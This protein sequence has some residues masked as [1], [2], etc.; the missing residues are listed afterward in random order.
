[1]NMLPFYDNPLTV[2]E[3]NRDRLHCEQVTINND[4]FLDALMYRLDNGCT[5][6]SFPASF[7]HWH[8]MS[9]KVNRWAKQGVLQCTVHTLYEPHRSNGHSTKSPRPV[10]TVVNGTLSKTRGAVASGK[11]SAVYVKSGVKKRDADAAV[12]LNCSASANGE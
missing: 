8:P 12:T 9:V 4:L 7:G 2:I 10:K 6:R 11:D 5:W 3:K 1:M